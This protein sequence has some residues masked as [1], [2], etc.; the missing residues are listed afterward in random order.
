MVS[1]GACRG[2]EHLTVVSCVRTCFKTTRVT[3][4][5]M[6]GFEPARWRENFC[7]VTPKRRARVGFA[8]FMEHTCPS[9]V[10]EDPFFVG[11][12]L[13]LENREE[14]DAFLAFVR[15]VLPRMLAKHLFLRFIAFSRSSSF[16]S[17]F[18]LR[19][20]YIVLLD[21]APPFALIC[22]GAAAAAAGRVSPP[23]P[24]G[25]AAWWMWLVS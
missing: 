20:L 15:W 19:F 14:N 10:P 13:P 9:R 3:A 5:G 23:P 1:A 8:T 24:K 12:A 25:P 17:L 7:C 21:L 18:S 22:S 4:L 2:G 11:F 6:G 16:L